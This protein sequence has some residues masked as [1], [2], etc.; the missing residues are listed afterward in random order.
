MHI[1]IYT[2]IYMHANIHDV[3]TLLTNICAH[4]YIHACIHIYTH[5]HIHMYTFIHTYELNMCTLPIFYLRFYPDT[6]IT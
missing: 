2:H 4:T 1:H 6:A 5:I 3:Y